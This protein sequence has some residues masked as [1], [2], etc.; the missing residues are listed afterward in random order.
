[1]SAIPSVVL[2]TN[3][4][5]KVT[6]IRS[7]LK[8][9][10]LKIRLLTLEDFP[11]FPP[12]AENKPTL[13]GNAKKKAIEVAKRTRCLA[14]A[15]DTGLFIRALKGKPGVYSARFAGPRCSYE[16]NNQKVLRLLNQKPY[17]QREAVFRTIAALATPQGKV[18][19]AE[20]QIKGRIAMEPKGKR[21]F[22]YDPIFYIP[23]FKKTF[24]ELNPQMKNKI[25]HR[26]H[27]FAQVPKLLKM[28][29]KMI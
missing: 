11:K 21:G 23:R 17:R 5:H 4:L 2:A 14:L 13:E 28:A 10:K 8:K 25:S 27:A 22:G 1:M 15:D 18:F 7:V 9:A 3:N 12:V 26:A 6:E 24:A 29:M 20:G 19:M 16:D